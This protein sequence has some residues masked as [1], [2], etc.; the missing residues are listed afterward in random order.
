[1]SRQTVYEG[2]RH[3]LPRRGAEG[4]QG[5]RCMG[6]APY[7]CWTVA[8]MPAFY[9]PQYNIFA[10]GRGG[11]ASVCSRRHYGDTGRCCSSLH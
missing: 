6:N 4:E 9:G 11:V 3:V 2:Q 10:S 1:M 7:C 5:A 8:G